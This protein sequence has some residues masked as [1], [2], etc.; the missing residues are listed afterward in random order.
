MAKLIVLGDIV[1]PVGGGDGDYLHSALLC[2][3]RC[4][5]GGG[6]GAD[7]VIDYQDI[8]LLQ[9]VVVHDVPAV[10]HAA[11]KGQVLLRLV[12]NRKAGL[13][14]G[15]DVAQAACAEEHLADGESGVS[16]AAV[17]V[18]ESVVL[19]GIRHELRGGLDVV[20]LLGLDLVEQLN[21][22]R[23]I[24]VGGISHF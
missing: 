13:H 22:E 23:K 10:V 19:D 9:V 1:L 24:S 6:V 8:V 11:L 15:V 3:K 20:K 17:D 2:L 12:E 21:D 4:V 5:D 7:V 16:A 18:Y 14:A